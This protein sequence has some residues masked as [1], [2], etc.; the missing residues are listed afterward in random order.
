MEIVNTQFQNSGYYQLSTMGTFIPDS[1][2][3]IYVADNQQIFFLIFLGS[4]QNSIL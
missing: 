1:S 4:E 2:E 3:W